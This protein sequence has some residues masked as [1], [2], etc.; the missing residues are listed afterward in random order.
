MEYQNLIEKYELPDIRKFSKIQWKRL[1]K[2]KITKQN[3]LDLLGRIKSGFK[4]L[5]YN[6]LCE[7]KFEIKDY[8]KAL[9]LP[10]ARL[11]FSLRT[12]MT[13]TVQMNFKGNPRYAKNGWKCLECDTSDTQDH[14]VRCR[15]YQDIRIGKDLNSDKD[16]VDY[17]RA[18]IKMREKAEMF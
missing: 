9:N 17:F 8:F 10:D 18:V 14:I 15:S 6:T 1:V 4:K 3:R 11:K 5:D 7:E 2:E 12:K 16:L 13:K